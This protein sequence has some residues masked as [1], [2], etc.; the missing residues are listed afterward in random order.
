MEEIKCK[1][2]FER[3]EPYIKFYRSAPTRLAWHP[4]RNRSLALATEGQGVELWSCPALERHTGFAAA[5]KEA[6]NAQVRDVAW[7]PDGEGLAWIFV[8]EEKGQLIIYDKRISVK[9]KIKKITTA[10]FISVSWSPDGV[11]AS[12]RHTKI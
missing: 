7:S 3:G 2:K 12:V 8:Q 11:K 4:S 10:P 6:R 9:K 1:A 5:Q